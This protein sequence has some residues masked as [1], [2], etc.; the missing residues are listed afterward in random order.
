[1]GTQDPLDRPTGLASQG[2]GSQPIPDTGARA[3][4]FRRIGGL[5]AV[6]R[7]ASHARLDA[8]AKIG[9]GDLRVLT[10][11]LHFPCARAGVCWGNTEAEPAR[12]VGGASSAPVIPQQTP[13]SVPVGEI[14]WGGVEHPQGRL[15]PWRPGVL[16]VLGGGLG[17]LA[18]A[19]YVVIRE[20]TRREEPA[21][22]DRGDAFPRRPGLGNLASSSF[23][24]LPPQGHTPMPRRPPADQMALM[25]GG[26]WGSPG[27]LLWRR[28]GG[29][30]GVPRVCQP[31]VQLVSDYVAENGR[32]HPARRRPGVG[33]HD[34]AVFHDSGFQPRA[35]EGEEAC[36]LD[37]LAPPAQEHVVRDGLEAFDQGALKGPGRSSLISLCPLPQRLHRGAGGPEAV[38]A[39]PH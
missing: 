27:R 8:Q 32:G 21:R 39:V 7:P 15:A 6:L 18:Q 24:R 1:M 10:Q 11:A 5:T 38:G 9:G 26:L 4:P 31:A 20:A 17:L 33:G 37:A 22:E 2:M 12:P 36:I 29:R 14:R 30:G 28:E 35:A 3:A 19:P 13:A 16:E 23:R 34:V 25:P